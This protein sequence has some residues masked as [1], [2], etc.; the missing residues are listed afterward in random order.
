MQV[1]SFYLRP[2]G[3][4]QD[5]YSWCRHSTSQLE[6][7]PFC[8]G[9]WLPDRG[10]LGSYA[11]RNTETALTGSVSRAFSI[12]EAARATAGVAEWSSLPA[13]SLHNTFTLLSFHATCTHAN[14]A[15]TCFTHVFLEQLVY[16]GRVSD[17][18]GP[19]GKKKCTPGSYG[20]S[21]NTCLPYHTKNIELSLNYEHKVHKGAWSLIIPQY[22]RYAARMP[23][24][25]RVLASVSC[26]ATG[27]QSSAGCSAAGHECKPL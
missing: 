13:S 18:P 23:Y 4:L 16:T 27:V 7:T 14:P 6:N 22:G 20:C 3:M 5:A 8:V 26:T 24:T 21:R 11:L 10:F 15:H 1:T 17:K 25:T 2:S 9:L 12:R 19:E